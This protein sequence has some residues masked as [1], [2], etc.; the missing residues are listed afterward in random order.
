MLTTVGR[1]SG[2]P[3]INLNNMKERLYPATDEE[4]RDAMDDY[5]GFT[6]LNFIRISGNVVVSADAV[7]VALK[8]DP[9]EEPATLYVINR[10]DFPLTENRWD[11]LKSKIW[12]SPEVLVDIKNAEMLV[13]LDCG[14]PDNKAALWAAMD[15]DDDERI[16]LFDDKP[17]DINGEWH[18]CKGYIAE[19][20]SNLIPELTY[21]NSPQQV[22]FNLVGQ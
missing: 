11:A 19:I 1:L 14:K 2:F 15:S 22:T 6:S 12:A 17:R 3:A 7:I 5:G 21:D 10:E 18:G 20:D 9:D 13:G 4:I 16:Y 8:D